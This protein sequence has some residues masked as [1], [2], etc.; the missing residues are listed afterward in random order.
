MELKKKHAVTAVVVTH[1]IHGAKTFSDLLVLLHK[2]NIVARGTF[3]DLRKSSDPFVVRF[4][5]DTTG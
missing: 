1:D 3:E 4:L 2:G 5:G